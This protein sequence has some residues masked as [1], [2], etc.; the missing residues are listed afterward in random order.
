MHAK[1]PSRVVVW[2]VLQCKLVLGPL[3]ASLPCRDPSKTRALTEG[4]CC[5]GVVAD[6]RSR[7]AGVPSCC[8][9]IL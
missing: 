8:P 7:E 2:H 1:L 5:D 6:S 9:N 3:K 4:T